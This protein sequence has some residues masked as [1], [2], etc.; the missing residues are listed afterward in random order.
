MQAVNLLNEIDGGKRRCILVTNNEVSVEEQK[1]LISSGHHPGE[2]E[3]E[4][5]GI[6]HYVTW[7]RIVC[8]IEGHD[9]KGQPLKGIILVAIFLWQTDLKP[10]L[11]ISSWVS[12]TET[13]LPWGGNSKKCYPHCG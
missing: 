12:L 11:P 13:K 3:W 6:A 1:E 7:P 10:T 9:V 4:T 8:S 5:L 2:K